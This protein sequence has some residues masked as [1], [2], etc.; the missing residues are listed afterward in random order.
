MPPTHGLFGLSVILGIFFIPRR[1]VLDFSIIIAGAIILIGCAR[2]TSSRTSLMARHTSLSWIA[3]ALTLAVATAIIT[4]LLNDYV[5]VSSSL[6]YIGRTLRS[7][8]V[9][10]AFVVIASAGWLPR[11]HVIAMALSL[12][13]CIIILQFA[14]FP[15]INVAI[16]AVN[17]DAASALSAG[18]DHRFTGLL[19]S[20]D[21]SGLLASIL[22]VWILSILSTC[23][24]EMHRGLWVALTVNCLATFMTSRTALVLTAIA[25]AVMG[26]V[27]FYK[28][29]RSMPL[30]ALVAAALGACITA[31]SLTS[32][33]GQAINDI[34]EPIR[35][36]QEHGGIQV[37][38]V[39][40]IIEN[41]IPRALS[42]SSLMGSSLAPNLVEQEAIDPGYLQLVVG[43]GWIG[44]AVF[45]YSTWIVL[46]SIRSPLSK[47]AW[48]CILAIFLL[49]MFKGPY[50]YS[51]GVFDVMLL[52]A[53]VAAVSRMLPLRS[54]QTCE[55]RI[56]PNTVSA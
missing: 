42:Q 17:L 54:L 14:N 53:V 9:F 22:V 4:L 29:P 51:R 31:A 38:S 18:Y 43:L 40:D 13:S 15:Y 8:L 3:V 37:G 24:R 49:A 6:Y 1:G 52:L 39:H 5:D 50:Y 27:Y 45:F 19:P 46:L 25:L 11:P 21:S 55:L 10:L 34:T 35:T 12:N 26:C 41:H 47:T 7:L 30:M 56:K 16:S 28:R 23:R 32:A 20:F 36:M 33:G 44:L 2:L 48:A